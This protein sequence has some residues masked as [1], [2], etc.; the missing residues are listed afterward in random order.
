MLLW[1]P[2]Q[3]IGRGFRHGILP[4]TTTFALSL[5]PNKLHGRL[6]ASDKR[7]ASS[8]NALRL[9]PPPSLALLASTIPH[10]L[11]RKGI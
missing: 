5:L 10:G 3:H 8:D 7:N 4:I 9:S 1:L 2:D 6:Y 11:R